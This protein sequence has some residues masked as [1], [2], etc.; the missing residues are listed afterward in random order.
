MIDYYKLLGVTR[1]AS[2]TDLKKSYHQLAK[3]YHPDLNHGNASAENYFKEINVAY[4]TL[5][6]ANKRTLYDI[7]YQ[8]AINNQARKKWEAALDA[9]K[10]ADRKIRESQNR[11]SATMSAANKIKWDYPKEEES[12]EESEGESENS[13]WNNLA[14]YLILIWFIMVMF[15]EIIKK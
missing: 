5:S 7:K 2:I 9:A 4:D 13:I 12:E 8:N 10:E 3:K 11:T 1:N 14:T 15:Q 6:D